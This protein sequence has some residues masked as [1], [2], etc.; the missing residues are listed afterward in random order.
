MDGVNPCFC[1]KKFNQIPG[2]D[3][4]GDPD[5]AGDNDWTW[6]FFG[7]QN[8]DRWIHNP[9]IRSPYYLVCASNDGLGRNLDLQTG[10]PFGE[11]DSAVSDWNKP[12]FD[13]DG[14]ADLH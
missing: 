2:A 10:F 3:L 6:D 13:I 8:R 7:K 12:G 9:R 1:A 11:T 4:C 14:R 5:F